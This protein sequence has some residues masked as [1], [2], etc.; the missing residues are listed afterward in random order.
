MHTPQLA[1]SLVVAAFE[2]APE[3]VSRAL[4]IEA[5]E[6]WRA[7]EATPSG[8]GVWRGNEWVLR[9]PLEEPLDLEIHLEWLLERLPTERPAAALA[10][11]WTFEF[12]CAVHLVDQAPSLSVSSALLQRIAQLGASIDI[13]VVLTAEAR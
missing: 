10:A 3:V 4:G 5:T 2:D 13:D 6:S 1:V 11:G 9:S 7:G 12:S 8:R